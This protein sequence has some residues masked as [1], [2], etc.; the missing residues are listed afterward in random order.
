MAQTGNVRWAEGLEQL[1][2]PIDSVQQHPSNANNG[3][4]DAITESIR[5]NGYN[6]PIIVERQT[7]YI[8][9]GN[10]RWQ[11]L[12]GL[13]ATEVPVI[14]TDMTPEQGKR[15]MIADNR[16]AQLAM[17]DEA[18]LAAMLKDLQGSEIGLFG[19]GYTDESLQWLLESLA[20]EAIPESEGMG[21][22][23]M[24]LFQI[25][26]DFDGMEDERDEILAEMIERFGDNARKVDL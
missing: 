8:V 7:G 1:M 12:H 3:D 22:A 18:A 11:A 9:A 15:Y 4:I 6:A 19:T 5:V 17:Q 26:I 14:W 13:G 24:G 2:V 10:H 20:N 23:S 16:T 25:V 21:Q